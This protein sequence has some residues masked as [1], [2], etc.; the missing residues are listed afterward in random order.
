[1][2]HR[3]YTEINNEQSFLYDLIADKIRLKTGEKI[4]PTKIRKVIEI[5]GDVSREVLNTVKQAVAS[6]MSE[7]VTLEKEKKSTKDNRIL[8]MQKYGRTDR[9]SEEIADI[10]KLLLPESDALVTVGTEITFSEEITK[11]KAEAISNLITN[12]YTHTLKSGHESFENISDAPEHIDFIDGFN[13]AKYSELEKIRNN[14]RLE[15]D[16]DDMVRV[17][18]YFLSESREPT[19]TELRIADA[20]FSESFRHTTLKTVLSQVDCEDEATKVAWEHYISLKKSGDVSLSDIATAASTHLS[21]RSLKKATEKLNGIKVEGDCD[22]KK[23]LLLVKNES[24]NRS[25]MVSPYDGAANCLGGSVRD[26]LCALAYTFESSRLYGYS[27]TSE[28]LDKAIEAARGYSDYARGLGIPCSENAETVSGAYDKKQ[29][30]FCVA[31]ALTDSEKTAELLKKHAQDGDFIFLLGG[32]TGRD[33]GTLMSAYEGTKDSGTDF[34]G[35]YVPA[36]KSGVLAAMQRLFSDDS[37]AGF[38][39]SINDVGSGGIICAIS[40]ITEGATVQCDAVPLKYGNLNTHEILLSESQ[41]RMVVAVSPDNA[42]GFLKLCATYDVPC[43]KIAVVNDTERF[44]IINENTKRN[45]SLSHGFLMS[46]GYENRLGAVVEAQKPLPE[47]NILKVAKEPVDKVKKTLMTLFAHSK[48]NFIGAM[49]LA[50]K[51]ADDKQPRIKDCVDETSGN[52]LVYSRSS[53]KRPEVSVR[54]LNYNG[55]CITAKGKKLCS[56]IG[57]GVTNEISSLSP[58]KSAYLSVTEAVMKLVVSGYGSCERYIAIQEYFP[59]HEKNSKRLGVS[60]SSMLG[61]FEAQMNLK[62]ASIGGRG[63]VAKNHPNNPN[64]STVAVLSV[65]IGDRDAAI[66]RELKR[67]GSKLIL[68]KPETEH[69]SGLPTPEGQNRVIDT[70]NT[71]V[72]EKKVLSASVVNA[73]CVATE[74]VEICRASSKGVAVEKDCQLETLFDYFYGAAL[75]EIPE[76]TEL[77][78]GAVLIGTVTDEASITYLDDVFPISVK[79][80]RNKYKTKS[81]EDDFVFL[82]SQTAKY[83][84]TEPVTKGKVRVLIP[85]THYS[86][87]AIDVKRMFEAEG[88]GA[89][90][91]TVGKA[92]LKQFADELKTT[93]ILYIPDGSVSSAFTASLLLLPEIQAELKALKKRGGLIYGSGNSFDALIKSGLIELD[94]SRVGFSDNTGFPIAH[95]FAKITA[96]STLSPFMKHAC[97][98]DTFDTVIVGKKLRLT[99]DADYIKELAKSGRILTQYVEDKLGNTARIDA[100]CS[101]D[102]HVVGQISHPERIGSGLADRGYTALPFIKSAVGY[103]K[104]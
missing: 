11:E 55:K 45:A 4:L 96:I 28:N 19:L 68:I 44:T 83:G 89:D 97:P 80:S 84:I 94:A 39:N 67:C 86:I 69:T 20:F 78:K 15:M 27:S 79:A 58:Y 71:L 91:L 35:E 50:S 92:T 65:C 38:C 25:V 93:D 101:K 12:P 17:Q 62:T 77:P 13:A 18:N 59:K 81:T 73:D 34:V 16:M 26:L 82:K 61:V 23:L 63:Y 64:Q 48:K 30:E 95:S 37:F 66:T 2:L 87:P 41:E 31:L 42:E 43:S 75:L 22:G 103:F 60:L 72:A 51:V 52:G 8:V 32:K 9:K 24:C 6:E 104:K 90:I 33:G 57:S 88:A 99:A 53:M 54:E 5:S 21:P 14:Y 29:F 10:I 40:E 102:G 98:T 85:V 100:L 7:R 3:I 74:M 47:S 46:E 1:M 49:E 70:V 56:V 76:N 36:G